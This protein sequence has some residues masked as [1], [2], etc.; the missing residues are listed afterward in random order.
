MQSSLEPLPANVLSSA[1]EM[2]GEAVTNVEKAE[3]GA[4]NRVYRV[5]AGRR[6][7]ALK[8]YPATAGDTRD[9]LGTETAAI[10]FMQKH[11]VRIVPALVGVDVA[12]GI[13]LYEWIDGE[14]VG[15]A[16]DADI[17]AAARLLSVLHPLRLSAAATELPLA[18]EACL[19]GSE[20]V[21]QIKRRLARLQEV[22]TETP[23]LAALL[24]D[25]IVPAFQAAMVRA[26]SQYAD[27][28][29]D[30]AAS[31]DP[32]CR[33]LSPSDFGFHN[34][35][36]RFDRSLIFFD[37]EYFG[38]D[39]PVKPVC[40]FVLHPGM[41]MSH[42]QRRQFVFDTTEIY[43]A[44]STYQIRLRALYPLFGLRWCLILLN[45][46]LPERWARRVQAGVALDRNTV[47]Y[48]QLAKAEAMLTAV[49]KGF[50]RFP[51]DE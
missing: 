20:I 15:M 5:R 9:R 18:S 12:K 51:Y 50:A 19:A 41:T 47:F 7:Y 37:F 32:S 46:F 45:E 40:D 8:L 4:N 16:T 27:A 1:T 28:G 43:G 39:D 35:R 10:S 34:A 36:R 25:A 11:G 2:L 21:A 17:A 14:A 38:W 44:D 24:A 3:G 23:N 48:Q 29:L 26:Q 30:F 49:T 22:A 31:I 6:I 42:A 13:G 33:T